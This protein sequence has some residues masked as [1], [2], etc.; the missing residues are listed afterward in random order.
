[1]TTNMPK[2]A[3]GRAG[4]PGV[5]PG[6]RGLLVR[7][8]PE[9]IRARVTTPS[10]Q[11]DPRP[12]P[13]TGRAHDRITGVDIRVDRVGAGDPVVLLNGLLGANEHWFS[14]LGPLAE[15]AECVLLE[16]PL[17]EMRGKGLSVEGVVRLTASVLETLIDRPAVLVGN[18][19]GGHIALR[20]AI[21]HPEMVRGLVLLGSSGLFERTFER[22]AQHSPSREWLEGKIGD[23]FHDP[24]ALPS[25]Q[26]MVDMAHAEL[27]RRSA[28][29]AL[30]RLGRSA[31]ADHL[32]DLLP[33]ITAPALLLWGRQDRVT[34]PDVAAE[35]E[36][37]IPD[38]R[39]R[40]IESAGHAPHIERP[41]RVGEEIARF[42]DELADAE[43]AGARGHGAA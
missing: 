16:P 8:A 18:S 38:A 39:L 41:G 5:S 34:P 35:F 14:C 4:R 15:R 30:V 32:G 27:S 40:W 21:E 13:V 9:R 11:P 2:T 3:V 23:L 17:L 1:M 25:F 12:V 31:K 42:V 22:G 37:L 20:L 10:P 33:R 19:L 29:R 26:S 36:R 6:A 24:D 28:A 43:R 7:P